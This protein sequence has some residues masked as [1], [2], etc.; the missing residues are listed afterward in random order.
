MNKKVIPILLVAYFSIFQGFAQVDL[1][2]L[3]L[4]N[5]I[6]WEAKSGISLFK[7]AVFTKE[8]EDLEGK[9][10]SMIG[11]FLVL[12]GTQSIYMLSKN[13]MA[14]CFF[15]GNGGPETI[16]ELQFGKKPTYRMDDLISVVGVLRLNRDN[17]NHCYYLIEK[18]EALSL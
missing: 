7:E 6:S 8:L 12:E 15:C 10:V 4:Q 17:P 2:W 9:Q 16:V 13:P 3:A 5:G 18:A 1:D 14:S 11:Y